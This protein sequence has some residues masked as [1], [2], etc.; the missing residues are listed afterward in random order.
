MA[1]QEVTA[2]SIRQRQ[3]VATAPIAKPEVA[4]EIHTPDPIWSVVG[5]ERSF[6]LDASSRHLARHAQPMAPQ[7]FSSRAQ[8]AQPFHALFA[9][10]PTHQFLWPPRRVL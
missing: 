10:N 5:A 7:Y 8:R 2:K 1:A 6:M 4:L 9:F 3:R